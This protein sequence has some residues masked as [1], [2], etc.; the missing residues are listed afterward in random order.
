MSRATSAASS[1]A[2]TTVVDTAGI[3][4]LARALITTALVAM[5]LALFART[6]VVRL[7]EVRSNS[8]TETLQ[9]GDHVLVSRWVAPPGIGGL[10]PAVRRGDV[11][12]FTRPAEPHRELIKRVVALPGERVTTETSPRTLG[13]QQLFVVGDAGLRS[14]DSRHW[15]PIQASWLR[16][17]AI[18]ILFSTAPPDRDPGDDWDT[19]TGR[20]RAM[21]SRWERWWRP[22]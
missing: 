22:I 4:H 10:R 16:G 20:M 17:R 13:E 11:V 9:P 6:F 14:R 3:P 18:L 15:G 19:I 12:L 21:T 5:M 1:P 2:L 8:M 7:V